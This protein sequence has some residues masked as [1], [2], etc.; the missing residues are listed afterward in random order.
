MSN[1]FEKSKREMEN[2]QE[3]AER[4]ERSGLS[5]VPDSIEKRNPPEPDIL[6][7]LSD[8][9]SVAFELKEICSQVLAKGASDSLKNGGQDGLFFRGDEEA[10]EGK[11]KE[12]FKK[13]YETEHPMELLF[14]TYGA[15]FTFL[16]NVIPTIQCC[17]RDN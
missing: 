14:Y 1:E 12:A 7:R 5:I 6:C 11:I 15:S 8:G 2:F 3:F 10:E 9:E 13:H 4:S 16:A 17:C